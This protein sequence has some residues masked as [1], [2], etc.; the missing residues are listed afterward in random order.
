[1]IKTM[2]VAVFIY[3]LIVATPA[4]FMGAV[5]VGV[6]AMFVY[7]F[8]EVIGMINKPSKEANDSHK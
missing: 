3:F 7:L 4:V 5:Q 2:F 8:L 6:V 1:M